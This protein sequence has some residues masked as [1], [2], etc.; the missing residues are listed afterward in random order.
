MPSPVRLTMRGVALSSQQQSVADA[1]LRVARRRGA[2]PMEVKAALETGR[3]ESNFA[4]LPGGDADSA[5]WRQERGSL[6]R[7]P[8]N[9]DASINRFFDE[10]RAV[11]GKY[12]SAGDLAAAVQRPAARYR[13]RYAEHSAEADALLGGHAGKAPKVASVA[14]APDRSG[15]QQLAALL[16]AQGEQ[17]PLQRQSVGL[18][19]PGFA[20]QA[21]VAQAP[22]PVGAQPVLSSGGPVRESSGE[23]LSRLLTAA[24]ALGGPAAAEAPAK[25]SA[26]SDGAS[27]GKGSPRSKLLELFWQGPG[28]IN[29]KNGRAVPQGFVSGHT[30]HVHVAAGPKTTIALGKLAESMGL[31]VGE[32]DAFGGVHPV[33]VKGSNHYRGQ[34]VDVSGDPAKLRAFAHRVASSYGIK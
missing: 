22:V 24:S 15:G 7:D 30:D 16:L 27:A 2:S 17:Q 31:Q 14:A 26:A 34:A 8:T 10:T 33:H 11:R 28:G 4:N 25:P 18:Q 23:S 13:G 29:V 19:T 12:G 32:N 5:G 20:A 1:I 9:L 3:V 6:Y 21:P